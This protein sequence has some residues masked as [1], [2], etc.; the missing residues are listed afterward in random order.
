MFKVGP[1]VTGKDFIGRDDEM[2]TVLSA[3]R[4]GNNISI[5]GMARIGKTSLIKEAMRRIE[6][7]PDI[8]PLPASFFRFSLTR[9]KENRFDFFNELFYFFLDRCTEEQ[10]SD[11][12]IAQSVK[13]LTADNNNQR[14]S[15]A[16]H[17]SF[18][19]RYFELH[20]EEVWIVIDEMDYAN[21]ALGSCIEDLREILN[22]FPDNIHV[23]NI[24]RLSLTAIFPRDTPGSNYPGVISKNIAI[25]GFDKKGMEKYRTALENKAAEENMTLTEEMWNALLYYGGCIPYY[26]AIL[27]NQLLE[28]PST[29][30]D[31]LYL[32]TKYAE[33]LNYW[34]QSLCERKLYD[35]A[36]DFIEG[37]EN[38]DIQDLTVYGIIENGEFTIPYFKEYLLC[39]LNPEEYGLVDS[40]T[41]LLPQ[42]EI[43]LT[44]GNNIRHGVFRDPPELKKIQKQIH[45]LQAMETK[46]SCCKK[47]NELN[48]FVKMDISI[49][50]VNAFKNT[51]NSIN[52]FF[53]SLERIV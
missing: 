15:H 20:K 43:L 3:M 38:V 28:T 45:E 47:L 25:R 9:E 14:V 7:Q 22:A 19:K 53:E 48:T 39:H 40:Y 33:T 29:D 21:E 13:Q 4:N 34:Y 18:Y 16:H 11:R 26:L 24:S 35:N 6:E 30:P 1:P 37:E 36:I 32:N 51:I 8:L 17:I 5:Y 50:E 27:S 42:I 10:Q 52:R 49:N 31:K 23:I 2:S 46:I 44:L 41:D 12:R